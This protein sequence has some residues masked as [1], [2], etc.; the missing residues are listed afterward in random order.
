MC[1]AALDEG[2]TVAVADLTKAQT[3]LKN[4][5]VDTS[6]CFDAEKLEM[7]GWCRLN[8]GQKR[9]VSSSDLETIIWDII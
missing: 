9:L 1:D 2:F 4:T 5:G 7:V 6:A 8:P 3:V